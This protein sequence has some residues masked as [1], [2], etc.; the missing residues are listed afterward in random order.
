MNRAIF[1][2]ALAAWIAASGCA[3][4]DDARRAQDPESAGPGERTVAAREVGLTA[5]STLSLEKG[6][7]LALEHNPRI[8]AALL[9]VRQAEARVRQASGAQLPQVSLSASGRVLK[10]GTE[11]VSNEAVEKSQSGSLS[12]S[13]VLFDFGKSS[14][15]VR[16][17][18]EE[19][20]AAQ[21]ELESTRDDLAFELRQSFLSVLKQEELVR[22]AQETL[23]QF[24]KRLEQ[25]RGFVEVGARARYDLTK[26]QVDLGN[27]QLGLVRA[28]TQL[29]NTRAGLNALLGLAED[30]AYRLERPPGETGEI[31]S[32]ETLAAT[33]LAR[34]PRIQALRL[35]ESA[36]GAG[37]DAAV[38]DLMP[39]F[40]L[41]GSFSGSGTLTPLAWVASAGPALSWLL[42]GG[43]IRTAR[44]EESVDSLRSARSARAQAEQQV[45]S[46]VRTAA[47]N[48][49][50]ARERYRIAELTVLQAAE[51]LDLA[52]GRF[53][54]G[55]ASSVE[56][57]DA[58]VLLANAR[59]ELVQAE[60]DL[61]IA[62]AALRRA[63]GSIR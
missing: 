58:Q 63:A 34:N 20:N 25:V 12:V 30:P 26:A 59:G 2:A 8:A 5:E 33:A 6:L 61:Q 57:T 13:Q 7:E 44:L 3:G 23:R 53:E 48:V 32:L 31:P 9:R 43:G 15:A 35:R 16:Q 41:S 29:A 40:S 19:W 56:L 18:G 45:Y 27:A 62:L 36:A 52:Q 39:Q 1:P 14:A 54:V 42:F 11:G 51:N 22:V 47:A 46:E 49:S 28:R 4:I 21:A 37:V 24:D 50:D 55:R 60:F 17:A 10:S 38:A